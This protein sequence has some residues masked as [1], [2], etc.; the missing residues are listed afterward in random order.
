VTAWLAVLMALLALV[1]FVVGIWTVGDN[2]GRW[3]GTGAVALGL[4]VVAV[5]TY[6][7]VLYDD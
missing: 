5:L 1:L 4:S 2:S 6:V 7:L 3:G